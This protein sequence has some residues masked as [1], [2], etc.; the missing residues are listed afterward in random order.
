MAEREDNV[1]K[2]KLA[3]QAERYDGKLIPH[4]SDLCIKNVIID[5][6][7]RYWPTLC[8]LLCC[9]SWIIY[10]KLTELNFYDSTW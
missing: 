2:A 7:C 5:L 1:Y 8:L 10:D 4:K 6:D 3:E 9:F